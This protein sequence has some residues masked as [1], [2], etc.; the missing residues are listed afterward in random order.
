MRVTLYGAGAIGCYLAAHLATVPGLELSVIARGATLQAI[1]QAGIGFFGPQGEKR[2][3]VHATDD[4]ASLPV[5]DVVFI[6]LKA[7]QVDA[8]LDGIAR[9]LG[10]ETMVVPPTTGIPWWYFHGRGERQLPRLDPAGRQWAVIGPERAIGCTY[11]VG[12]DTLAPGEVH[13]AGD[14][15]FPIGE[16]SDAPSERLLLLQQVMTSAGLKAPIRADIRA[17][18]WAKMIN[19]LVWNPLAVLTGATLGALGTKPEIIALAHDMMAEAEA[20]ALAAGAKMATPAEKRIAW[21]MKATSH[22]MS[23]L[24]DLERGRVLEY[25]ILH[26]SIM[27]MRELYG[28]TTPLIDRV[29]AM[30]A[31]RAPQH[32][33]K[34]SY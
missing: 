29:Y 22:K 17:E 32:Q 21:T 1:R 5:Q 24:Q 27:A 11:W 7:H 3:R 18:I 23:M 28:L 34:P 9:L 6:T 26:D 20:V 8:A 30:L 33:G 25:A 4:P 12:A 19:S 14:A 31:L 13:A 16:P 15:G 10:P 2:V